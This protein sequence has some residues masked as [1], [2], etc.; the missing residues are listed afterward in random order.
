[1]AGSDDSGSA[2]DALARLPWAK[3]AASI[4]AMVAVLTGAMG[5]VNQAEVAEP[6][7]VA[8]RSFVRDGI[9]QATFKLEQRQIV[10]QIYL[11]NSERSRIENELANKQVLLDQNPTMPQG[12]RDTINEQIRTLKRTLEFTTGQIDD[13]RREQSGR[14]P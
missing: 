10:T 11:A 12:I 9:T 5:F 4:G 2:V 13:L 1:M 7:W 8:T 6:H 14:R 3:K